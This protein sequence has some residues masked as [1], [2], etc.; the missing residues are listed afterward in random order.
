MVDACRPQSTDY[1]RL[2]RLGSGMNTARLARD[3]RRENEF[4]AE[5]DAMVYSLYMGT[6]P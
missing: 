4:R 3:R 6:S 2:K 1:A 5:H